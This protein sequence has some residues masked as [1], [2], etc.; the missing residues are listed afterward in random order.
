MTKN[1]N[2]N[3]L[4]QIPPQYETV[5]PKSKNQK[6]TNRAQ[7]TLVHIYIHTWPHTHKNSNTQ[8]HSQTTINTHTRNTTNK[9]RL[10]EE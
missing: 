1:Q 7:I 10:Q 4:E 5:N 3:G 8:T 6:L 2:H 9:E